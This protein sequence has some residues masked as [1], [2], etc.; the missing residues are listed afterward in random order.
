[1]VDRPL[2]D[3]YA[4]GKKLPVNCNVVA[5]SNTKNLNHTL[6]SIFQYESNMY[7]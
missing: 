3:G 5:K 6:P 4:Y 1:M 2:G 7:H